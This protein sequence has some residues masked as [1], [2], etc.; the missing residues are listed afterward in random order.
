MNDD[1]EWLAEILAGAVVA[2]AVWFFHVGQA[3]P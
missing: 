2:L 3:L 1:C